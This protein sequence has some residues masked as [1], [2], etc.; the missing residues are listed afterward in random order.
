MSNKLLKNEQFRIN[1]N[2]KYNGRFCNTESCA[3]T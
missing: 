1:L 3:I 2:N